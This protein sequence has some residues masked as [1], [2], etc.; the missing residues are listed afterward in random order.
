MVR[1]GL[2]ERKR[3]RSLGEA[4]PGND[5]EELKVSFHLGIVHRHGDSSAVRGEGSETV[6]VTQVPARARGHGL[7]A[8]LPQRSVS[9]AI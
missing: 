4:L 1:E 8:P 2:L 7:F 9:Y 5:V 6:T 3:G